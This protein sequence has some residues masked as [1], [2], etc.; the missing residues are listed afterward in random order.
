MY[1]VVI[2]VLAFIQSEVGILLRLLS[3]VITIEKRLVATQTEFTPNLKSM[4]GMSKPAAVT[5]W[6]S[7]TD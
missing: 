4:A 3:I 6:A 1:L 5:T 7:L 2:H